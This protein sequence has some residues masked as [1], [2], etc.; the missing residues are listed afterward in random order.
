M[1]KRVFYVLLAL[2]AV[3]Q[4]IRPDRSVPAHD[5]ATDML[6]MTNAREDVRTA[7]RGACYDCH[8][9]E[10]DYPWYAAITPVNFI[11][12]D[13]IREGREHLNFSRWDTYATS[14]DASECGEVLQKDEMPPGYYQLMHGHG[15]LDAAQKQRLIAW[16][17]ANVT[18]GGGT[19]EGHGEERNEEGGE[20][21]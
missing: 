16:F 1:M 4:F 2:F 11:M 3:S 21:H 9:Y 12:Q 10:T 13:H 7:V 8:S 19:R 15:R 5:P 18:G 6:T 14:K 20:G 17:D